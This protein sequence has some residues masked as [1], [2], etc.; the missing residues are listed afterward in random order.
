MQDEDGQKENNIIDG[1][2]GYCGIWKVE[3]CQDMWMPHC[4]RSS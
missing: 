1:I 2:M 3:L 4:V